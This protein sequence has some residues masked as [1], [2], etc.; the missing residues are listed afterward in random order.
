MLFFLSFF[1]FSLLA[2]NQDDDGKLRAHLLL[3]CY[4]FH[5]NMATLTN[6]ERTSFKL[7]VAAKNQ[8]YSSP[9]PSDADV[10]LIP[11]KVCGIGFPDSTFQRNLIAGQKRTD[12]S[13]FSLTNTAASLAYINK[14]LYSGKSASSRGVK[15]D[16]AF[17][18]FDAILRTPF[19]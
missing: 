19:T 7:R 9:A 6:P 16:V 5:M 14:F 1:F 12:A 18:L 3:L 2:W 17:L 13:E 15:D 10:A 11:P 8:S 4:P